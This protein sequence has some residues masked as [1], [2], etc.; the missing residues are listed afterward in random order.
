VCG[1]QPAKIQDYGLIGDCRSAALVSRWGSVDWLCWPRFDSPA[2]FSVLLDSDRGGCWRIA[3][4]GAFTTKRAY[5]TGSN[6]LETEFISSNGRATLT[7]LIPVASQE[8]KHENL[9]P[10]HE[11]LRRVVCREGEI[12][13]Q[14]DFRPRANYGAEPVKICDD[15]SGGLRTDVGRGAYWLRSSVLLEDG[16]DHAHAIIRM[17]RGETLDFSLSY[18]EESPAILPGL[19]QRAHEAIERSVE[20]WRLWIARMK[21]DGPYAEAV[22]RSALALK[23]LAYSP[24]G[25]IV[26][27]PTTSL[28]ERIG[29]SLNW[30]YR[31]CWL[32][33]ASLTV[34]A[35][36]GLGYHEEAESFLGWL[37]H[38][39]HLTQP[40][41]R[42]LYTV[43][44]QI[45]PREK[46]LDYLQG[47][48]DS[49]PV[50]I[51][52][53]ARE[54][55][56]LDVYG[57]VIEAS[58][59][60]AQQGCEFDR[61]TQKLLIG[62][63]NYVAANWDRPDNGIWEPRTGRV[64]N[65]YSRLL[66]WTA[67]DRLLALEKTGF[68]RGVPYERLARERERIRKHI[69]QRAWNPRLRSYTSVLD[70]DEVDATLLRIPWFGFEA[71]DS[72]R[73][74]ST[75]HRVR[76]TLGAGN[77][78]LYR[79]L[80]EPP[81]GAFGICSFW[82]V[83]YVALGGATLEHAHRLFQGLLGYANDLGLFAEETDPA[84]GEALGNFPQAFTHIGLISAALTLKEREQGKA[85]P[86]AQTAKEAV[87]P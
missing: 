15:G 42:I 65:T 22:S 12:V 27:A 51:G 43:F 62:F 58:A 63:G 81:E 72:E 41:L 39:T 6:V 19:G 35:L 21:Y 31:Y 69:E 2:I 9:C 36:L 85:P 70:G 82:G 56:Q 5:L 28:P 44:G 3:P 17:K 86:P 55:L 29:D 68:V 66:C 59:Q 13:M 32:R 77:G 30:D 74:K 14:I 38:A 4:T 23:L 57:E 60:C 40:E 33:D 26:A 61:T 16:G 79:Y 34:R 18:A 7:D 53:E 67:L 84:T 45:A 46:T 50:R 49:R 75:Y 8:F 64:N 78:L 54:Q 80:R 37:L 71:A 87:K 10:D 47:F 11:L 83:E 73:M 25:A 20:W 1:K 24:S 48:R 52:N 76:E